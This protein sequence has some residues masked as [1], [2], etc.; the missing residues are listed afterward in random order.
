MSR[1]NIHKQRRVRMLLCSIWILPTRNLSHLTEKTSSTHASIN[2]PSSM[3]VLS[4]EGVNTKFKYRCKKAQSLIS[5]IVI[6]LDNQ[7]KTPPQTATSLLAIKYLISE[8]SKN[9]RS[10]PRHSIQQVA[11]KNR[12]KACSWMKVENGQYRRTP[13]IQSILSACRQLTQDLTQSI[14]AILVPFSSILHL[15]VVNMLSLR[16]W[17]A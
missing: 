15:K 8:I 2:H 9:R 7:V 16:Q 12:T 6:Q 17:R 10:L 14:L 3:N 13:L 11:S 1:F 4:K 5:Q